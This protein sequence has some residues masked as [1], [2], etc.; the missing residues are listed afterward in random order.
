M[1]RHGLPLALALTVAV[2]GC[3]APW[4]PAENYSSVSSGLEEPNSLIEFPESIARYPESK[5][6]QVQHAN[7]A[8]NETP[9]RTVLAS[10]EQDRSQST[11]RLM[12]SM[13]DDANELLSEATS[14]S[15][16]FARD[17]MLQRAKTA[18]EQVL[19]QD[20]ENPTAHHRLGV[21][22]DL[23]ENFANAEDHY[24]RALAQ[25]PHDPDL[26]SDI[27][28]SYQL[29]ERSAVA[30]QFLQRALDINP[31][32]AR[33]ASNLGR[34]KAQR[35]E[36]DA[37]YSLFERAG[38]KEHADRAIAHFFPD[39]KPA[40][41]ITQV[42]T[43][44]VSK[45]VSEPIK[46]PVLKA[47][48]TLENDFDDIEDRIAMAREQLHNEFEDIEPAT[49]QV[50]PLPKVTPRF[51]GSSSTTQDMFAAKAP[52]TTVV[53]EVQVPKIV[54]APQTPAAPATRVTAAPGHSPWKSVSRAPVYS[55][56]QNTMAQQT[57][58]LLAAQP[59][60]GVISQPAVRQN[61]MMPTHPVDPATI[62][63]VQSKANRLWERPMEVVQR[64]TPPTIN[65][66][67][68]DVS[69][70]AATN[71][72]LSRYPF[73][74]IVN[75]PI[76]EPTQEVQT[77]SHEMF[78]PLPLPKVDQ[79]PQAWPGLKQLPQQVMPQANRQPIELPQYK[80]PAPPIVV[81][82]KVS[83]PKAPAPK[84][85]PKIVPKPDQIQLPT[86]N[87]K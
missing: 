53:P 70:V 69:P 16:G 24:R 58:P 11:R 45:E 48:S 17:Q 64:I 30:E 46:E 1:S 39:G 82:P 66:P 59:V 34:L 29:Q 62:Q 68:T 73:S 56:N 3:H 87:P 14:E 80:L 10:S 26:L 51:A 22:G 25:T 52:T 12:Q 75:Q 40:N 41:V 21:I 18:Y 83:V 67:T 35:G 27:G 2:T 85:M 5:P 65:T 33:A 37:A 63:Q 50:E 6:A 74:G 9:A 47:V 43:N 55:L 57:R 76:P 49:P 44:N 72:P 19:D 28:Y 20:A 8:S 23:E 78:E 4:H 71:E 31:G 79:P 86:I 15:D 61:I 84:P 38:S 81:Q 54:V 77:V 7:L 32:H 60:A 42:V 36:Y 13:L